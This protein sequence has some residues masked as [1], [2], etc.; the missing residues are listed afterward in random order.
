[1]EK[2]IL[3]S[4]NPG[5][6]REIQAIIKDVEVLSLKDAEEL[7][8]K[9]IIVTEEQDTFKGNALE[10]V[11]GLYEQVGPGFVCIADDSGLSIDALN[12]FPG[13]F[14]ARWM[15]ADDHTKNLELIK[16]V[17]ESGDNSRVCHY[18]TV[19]ALKSDAEERCFEST[20]DGT[21]STEC[22]G[23]NGFGFDEIFV[24]PDG[25]TLA[26]IDMEKKNKIS[27]RRKAL[28]ALKD[29][30]DNEKG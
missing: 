15:D 19:I 27:P 16:K 20:L 22:R 18:T 4:S 23:T 2:I 7:L 28:D 1:M 25:M 8:G 30:L 24:L 13:V 29:Y 10:K 5:K 12:G 11:R 21:V 6:I 26:E 9:K 17:A 14:T 3:A